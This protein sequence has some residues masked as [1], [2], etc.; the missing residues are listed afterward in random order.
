MA[1][2]ILTPDDTVELFERFQALSLAND[3]NGDLP[4]LRQAL[5]DALAHSP[6]A[7]LTAMAAF[8]MQSYGGFVPDPVALREYVERPPAAPAH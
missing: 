7:T 2:S 4:K 8:I 5:A 6:E 3:G 1:A